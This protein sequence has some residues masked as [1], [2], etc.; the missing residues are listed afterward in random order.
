MSNKGS[1]FDAKAISRITSATA[2]GNSGQV[3]AGS[4]A[5]KVQ[6][7]AAKASAPVTP[8]SKK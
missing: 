3:P 1:S 5:A 2:K 4:F 6:S 7:Q 8:G